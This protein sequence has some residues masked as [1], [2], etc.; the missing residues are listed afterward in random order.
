MP[1]S[2]LACLDLYFFLAAKLWNTDKVTVPEKR[3]E[4]SVY[5]SVKNI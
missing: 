2:I 4:I 3:I 5:F 1:T